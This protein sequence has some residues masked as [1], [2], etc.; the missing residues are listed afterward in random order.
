M[1]E[2]FRLQGPRAPAAD[3]STPRQGNHGASVMESHGEAMGKPWESH[4]EAM[5]HSELTMNLLM[6]SSGAWHNVLTNGL[7]HHDQQSLRWWEILSQHMFE[8]HRYR[9]SPVSF[10]G[11]SNFCGPVLQKKVLSVATYQAGSASWLPRFETR[12]LGALQS[13]FLARLLLLRTDWIYTASSVVFLIPTF[14]DLICWN[15]FHSITRSCPYRC[16]KTLWVSMESRLQSIVATLKTQ[17]GVQ[18]QCLCRHVA[19]RDQK[20]TCQGSS[21]RLTQQCQNWD[22]QTEACVY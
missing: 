7:S 8:C 10:A 14:S 15:E 3:P 21:L 12:N 19:L 20:G 22:L 13:Q 18:W 11:K 4:G 17:G 9:T 5:S 1:P 6:I 2:A 16:Q